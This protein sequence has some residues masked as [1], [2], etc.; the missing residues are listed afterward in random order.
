[1]TAQGFE[2]FFKD[3]GDEWVLN[4]RVVVGVQ[5]RLVIR[6]T[7]S[8]TQP[9]FVL[10]PAHLRL[11]GSQGAAYMLHSVQCDVVYRPFPKQQGR[12]DETLFLG[13]G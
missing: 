13:L 5:L 6:C 12:A 11:H 8:L 4:D 9:S 7:G 1:M 10:N 3:L 2:G